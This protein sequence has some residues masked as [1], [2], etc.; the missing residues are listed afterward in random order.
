MG[1]LVKSK[2]DTIAANTCAMHCR[3]SLMIWLWLWEKI[4]LSQINVQRGL[5]R[6]EEKLDIVESNLC[7]YTVL[8]CA[9]KT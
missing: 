1:G 2:S 8:Y 9:V 7:Y 4:R 5:G 3:L 6:R